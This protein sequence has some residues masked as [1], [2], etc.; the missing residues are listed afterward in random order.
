MLKVH[1]LSFVGF[2]SFWLVFMKFFFF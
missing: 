2:P 1:G